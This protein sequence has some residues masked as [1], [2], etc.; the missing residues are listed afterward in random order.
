MGG[1]YDGVSRLLAPRSHGQPMTQ[2][3]CSALLAPMTMIIYS[4]PM[5]REATQVLERI[6]SWPEEDRKEIADIAAAIEARRAGVYVLSENEVVAV[7][8]GLRDAE[9]GNLVSDDE[10]EKVWA[11]FRST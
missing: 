4:S 11:R 1:Q 2:K 8:E 7:Q 5:D 10:M 3:L 9:L 6:A